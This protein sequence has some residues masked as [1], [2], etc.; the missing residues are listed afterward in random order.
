MRTHPGSAMRRA[1]YLAGVR[2]RV[3]AV[4]QAVEAILPLRQAIARLHGWPSY[5]HGQLADTSPG[6]PAG[7]S[8]LMKDLALGLG[9]LVEEQLGAGAHLLQRSART[10]GTA[11]QGCTGGVVL[12]S[13]DVDRAWWVA[14]LGSVQPFFCTTRGMVV[15][16][17]WPCLVSF[18]S[19]CWRPDSGP[20]PLARLPFCLTFVCDFFC[21][22]LQRAAACPAGPPSAPALGGRGHMLHSGGSAGPRAVTPAVPRQPAGASAA[23]AAWRTVASST[24]FPSGHEAAGVQHQWGQQAG[25]G[26]EGRGGSRW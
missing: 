7:V 10:A 21:A 13:G 23:C 26:P 9:P 22:C 19:S 25:A 8:A 17:A 20:A 5:A 14:V 18:A 2:H 24:G 4:A 11:A 12:K 1:V 15:T 16:P 3:R 6:V